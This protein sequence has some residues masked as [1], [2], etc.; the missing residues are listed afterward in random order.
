MEW[1]QARG[2]D[3]DGMGLGARRL[4]CGC[5]GGCEGAGLNVSLAMEGCPFMDV[6]TR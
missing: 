1:K 2:P 4:G 6:G 3:G 5:V